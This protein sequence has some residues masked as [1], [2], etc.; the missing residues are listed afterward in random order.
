MHNYY[1]RG[2]STLDFP[3]TIE[4]ES[5]VKNVSACLLYRSRPNGLRKKQSKQFSNRTDDFAESS[6]YPLESRRSGRTTYATG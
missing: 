2:D 3:R 1:F 5:F 4:Y 6:R